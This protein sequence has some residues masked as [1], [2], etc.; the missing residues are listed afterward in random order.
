MID[1]LKSALSAPI[2]NILIVGSLVFFGIAVLGKY[3]DQFNIG[4][5]ARMSS[6]AIGII[7]FCSGIS[8]IAFTLYNTLTPAPEP[9]PGTG[10]TSAPIPGATATSEAT[11]PGTIALPTQVP[12]PPPAT[13]NACPR[14]TGIFWLQYPN[15][16]YGDP[17]LTNGYF[18]GW[19]QT[20]GFLVWDP[21]FGQQVFPDPY[22]QTQRNV[23][24][25]L[26]NS[27]FNICVES[28]TGYVF[29][30]YSP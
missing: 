18:V 20:G 28:G 27:P 6:A 17:T 29:G 23:W 5:A 26:P 19:N 12:T 11:P 30:Q 3:K 25:R 1:L 10:A 22:A 8:M 2:P 9:I 21:Q 14:V 16:W 24:L 4:N 13:V 7:L 15:T